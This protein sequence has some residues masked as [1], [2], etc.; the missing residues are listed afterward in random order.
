MKNRYNQIPREVRHSWI[1]LS[2][3]KGNNPKKIKRRLELLSRPNLVLKDDRGRRRYGIP[4]AGDEWKSLPDG[5]FAVLV[6]SGKPLATFIVGKTQSGRCSQKAF[7][8]GQLFTKI[9]N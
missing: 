3:I 9:P 5:T 1:L 7:Y 4:V 2:S 8:A 6:S